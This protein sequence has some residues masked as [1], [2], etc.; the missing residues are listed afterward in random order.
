MGQGGIP[1]HVRTRAQASGEGERRSE[2][3]GR[4]LE[5]R[6]WVNALGNMSAVVVVATRCGRHDS[7]YL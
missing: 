5:V 6:T 4:R 7:K 1:T 3:E 2:I